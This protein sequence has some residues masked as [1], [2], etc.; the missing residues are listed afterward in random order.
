MTTATG[1]HHGE[2]DPAMLAQVLSTLERVLRC[3]GAARDHVTIIGGLVPS[4]LVPAPAGNAHVGTGDVDLCLTMALAEGDTGYYDEVGPALQAAGF[5]QTADPLR[6]FR[7]A[8][9]GI[10]VDFLYPA[11]GGEKPL[12]T[13]RAGEDWESAALRS[14]GE[15]FAALAVGYPNLLDD[16]RRQVTFST[17]LDGAEVPDAQVHVSGPAALAALKADALGPSG[18]LKPKDAY[19][20]VWTLDEIGPERAA[21]ETIELVTGKPAAVAELLTAIDRLDAVF[22]LGRAGPVWYA[23]FVAREHDPPDQHAI[24]ERFAHQ[25]VVAFIVA[26]R[27]GLP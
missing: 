11:A 23:N 24:S 22:D 12:L 25:T 3:F 27:N 2:Y 13:T 6:R 9:N 21:A 19:D 4:L 18:R 26:L 7:W 10:V 1:H 20:V 17:T 8:R 14:L 5:G 15:N 16:T